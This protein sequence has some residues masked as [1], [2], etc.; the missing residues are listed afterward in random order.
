M[1]RI[2]TSVLSL[3][4][5]AAIATGIVYAVPRMSAADRRTGDAPGGQ[6]TPQQKPQTLAPDLVGRPVSVNVERVDEGSLTPVSATQIGSNEFLIANYRNV[7]RLDIEARQMRR[8][9]LIGAVPEWTPTAVHY[10]AFYDRVF[11]ANYTGGDV[12]VATVAPD[13][14][15]LAERLTDHIVGPEGVTISRGGRFMAVADYSADALSVFE[16]IND[17]W[18]FRWTRPAKAAH[19]VAIIDSS[20]FVAGKSITK[21]DIETGRQLASADAP[22]LFATSLNEDEQTGELIGSDAM[23]GRVFTMDTDLHLT[24]SFGTNGPTYSNLS[25]PYFAWRDRNA[26]WVLSTYQERL[27]RIDPSGTTSLEFATPSWTYIKDAAAFRNP[28]G[29]W[30]GILKYDSPAFDFLGTS[31]RPS[32]GAVAAPNGAQIMLPTREIGHWPY[33]ISTIASNGSHLAIV[34]NSSPMAL[35][36]DRSRQSLAAVDMGEWDCWAAADRVLCPSRGYSFSDLLSKSSPIALDGP[37]D[38]STLLGLWREHRP[39]ADR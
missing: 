20:V 16:R 31:I 34:A 4:F 11:I 27:L 14:L 35:L 30:H 12:I 17:A 37:T 19:G 5:V 36:Y 2:R 6:R 32:Y 21:F 26:L 7:Y 24:S 39:V 38:K 22:I 10:S 1:N 29:T 13:G 33:Y 9:P 3:L 28:A 25:M 15:H 8:L 23:T 18:V